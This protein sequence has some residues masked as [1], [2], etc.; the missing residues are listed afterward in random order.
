VTEILN[1]LTPLKTGSIISKKIICDVCGKHS[2]YSYI[3]PFHSQDTLENICPNCIASGFAAKKY[4]GEFTIVY[5]Y[6][7]EVD[8][9][10]SKNELLYR[11]PGFNSIQESHWLSH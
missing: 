5:D 1:A 11:T 8:S 3:G 10:E 9:D 7:C 2:D 4:D 6:E